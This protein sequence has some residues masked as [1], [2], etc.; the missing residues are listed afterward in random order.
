MSRW[1]WLLVAL[2]T[3]SWTAGAAATLLTDG[4]WFSALGFS[5]LFQRVLGMQLGAAAVA[6]LVAAA[7]VG[8]SARL[9]AGSR[10]AP[11]VAPRDGFE[12]MRAATSLVTLVIAGASALFAAR[13]W[14]LVA[15][16]LYGG[17]FATR[18][19]VFGHDIGFYVFDLPL[20]VRVV[21]WLFGLVVA[22]TVV[23]AAHYVGSG[24][25]RVQLV[26]QDGQLVATGVI[27]PR[28]VKRH[29]ASLAAAL[30]VLYGVLSFLGRYAVLSLQGPLI[31]GASYAD[32]YGTLPL[33]LAQAIG[34]LVA[35]VLVIVAA[36]RGS[37]PGVVGSLALVAALR[38]LTS[39]VPA[40]IQALSVVP[41]ELSLEAPQL[42][43][44]LAATREA[45]GLDRIAVRSL[46]GEARLTRE[47]IDA[48]ASTLDNVALWDHA[49][50]LQALGAL[51]EV[52][53]YYRFLSVDHDRYVLDGRL[54]QVVVAPREL[55]VDGLAEG[56]RTWVNRTMTYTHGYGV[57]VTA[58]NAV[59]DQGLP[60]LLVRD[61]PPRVAAADVAL[62]VTRP[63]I[64]FGE[65]D[66]TP[67]LVGTRNPEFDYTRGED[68][69]WG[70]YGGAEGISVAGVIPRV[71]FAVRLSSVQLLL[72][73]DL[74][75]DSKVV[76]F[77]NVLERVERIA[78]M[79][80]YDSDPYLVID[81]G[82]LVWML[83]GYT[84]SARYPYSAH[85][86]GLGSYAR[87]SV[88]VTVDAYDGTVHFYRVD[89]ADPIADAWQAAFPG[90]LAPLAEMPESLR[91]HLRYPQD[92]FTAQAMLFGT[93]HM[94]DAQELYMREDAWR[95]PV[96]GGQANRAPMQPSYTMMELPGE[97]GPE[98]I[99]MLP[100]SP[101]KKQNL[102]AWV[103]ARADGAQYGE[104]VTYVFPKD[105]T[106]LGPETIEANIDAEGE[107]TEKKT[108]WGQQGSRVVLGPLLVVPVDESLLYV[109]AMHVVKESSDSAVPGLKRVIVAYGESIAIAPTLPDAINRLF[110]RPPEPPAA[111]V[112][113]AVAPGTVAP[114]AT[115]GELIRQAAA[116]WKAADAAARR[117]DW[118]TF[119]AQMQALGG[120]MSALE[121]VAPLP[122]GAAP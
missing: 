61:V 56:A 97:E 4:W 18:E 23:S 76:L 10:R 106:V 74:T 59:T 22:A 110:G 72:S 21:Q 58:A 80:R 19:P 37:V 104:L 92:L 41:A 109:R 96:L 2:L 16:A 116:H 118:A 77:R 7:V 54:R 47:E 40:A 102:M 67:V 90:L 64:Y 55:D 50:L 39:L 81:Q 120:V 98:F 84:T 63:E 1:F 119:G 100:F 111:I 85:V 66:G 115:T 51:Q 45:W 93:Y 87:S 27:L 3:V 107:V 15:Q 60:E 6:F 49:A 17:S 112:T 8:G 42:E 108:L 12:P 89:V 65:S 29:A 88:K 83:D 79:F 53:T 14:P 46:R 75:R 78:P 32:L 121:G 114:A 9:A 36:S 43:R 101:E 73:R 68:E 86:P 52:R 70:R 91:A 69:Q 33:L 48:N 28:E 25:V 122:A 30:L 117:G 5:S 34:A 62:A 31:V 105:S 95:V 35:A 11:R 103:V 38:L 44:H 82:R 24:T 57:V 26:Q 71:A 13:S 94:Q 20:I 113:P 99:L